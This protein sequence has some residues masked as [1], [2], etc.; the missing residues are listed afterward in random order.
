M[1]PQTQKYKELIEILEKYVKETTAHC[2][3]IKQAGIDCVELMCDDP[4]AERCNSKLQRY[5][6]GIQSA[7]NQIYGIIEGLK[8]DAIEGVPPD[9]YLEQHPE[10]YDER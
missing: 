3:I 10:W 4:S 6:D 9:W 1:R 7:L 5:V 2:D 8:E